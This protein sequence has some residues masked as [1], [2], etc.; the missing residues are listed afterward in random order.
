MKILVASDIHANPFPLK[1][2]LEESYD[3]AIF[4]GDSVDYGPYPAE[5]IDLLRDNFDLFIMGNHDYAVAYGVDCKC[6]EENHDISVYSRENITL[7]ILSKEDIDFLK[8]FKESDSINA[9]SV[10]INIYHGAPWD[11]LYGYIFP[12][13][14]ETLSSRSILGG[15]DGDYFLIGHTH[16]QFILTKGGKTFINPGSLGQPRD[17]VGFPSYLI[18]DTEKHSFDFKRVKYDRSKLHYEIERIV[19]DEKMQS[20][21][22]A[23]F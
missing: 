15:D 16:H 18:I 5:V 23:M 11:H 21:L 4:L 3:K 13:K 7:K 6:G 19:R 8:Q 12:W 14:P 2:A 1:T 9:E 22:K 20:R 17:L 10:E